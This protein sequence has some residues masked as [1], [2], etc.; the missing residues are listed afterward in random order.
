MYYRKIIPVNELI[1]YLQEKIGELQALGEDEIV[2]ADLEVLSVESVISDIMYDREFRDEYL[3]LEE[4][5]YSVPPHVILDYV[6]YSKDEAKTDGYWDTFNEY[7]NEIWD[8]NIYP[9]IKDQLKE[10][11]SV[12]EE[13]KKKE[14]SDEIDDLSLFGEE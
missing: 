3:N 8:E 14:E 6:H 5:L 12:K 7:K 13:K 10:K 11:L 2:A 4:C 9:R 1:N